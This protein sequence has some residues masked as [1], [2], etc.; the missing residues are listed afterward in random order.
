MFVVPFDLGVDDIRLQAVAAFGSSLY[1]L[2]TIL[3]LSSW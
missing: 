3:H 1:H 2:R